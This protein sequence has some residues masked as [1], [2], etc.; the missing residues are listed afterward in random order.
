[1]RWKSKPCK[2]Y[3]ELSLHFNKDLISRETILPGP[4]QY[5]YPM[6]ILNS[7]KE[8]TQLKLTKD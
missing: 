7:M 3:L 1:M 2:I 8:R 4:T 5:W 6:P